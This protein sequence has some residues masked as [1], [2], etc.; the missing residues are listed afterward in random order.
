[1]RLVIVVAVED[2]I[3]DQLYLLFLLV[4][5]EVLWHLFLCYL[6]FPQGRG[7]RTLDLVHETLHQFLTETIQWTA[8][9]LFPALLLLVKSIEWV[10]DRFV[11]RLRWWMWRVLM[12]RGIHGIRLHFNILLYFL[13]L[14]LLGWLHFLRGLVIDVELVLEEFAISESGEFLT[15]LHILWVTVLFTFALESLVL[16]L[17]EFVGVVLEQRNS[18]RSIDIPLL[19]ADF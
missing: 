6:S 2:W 17:S 18:L 5:I 14:V 10:A 11:D 9:H 19:F 1:M 12:M 13:L 3:I 7:V 4:I 16:G 15:Q 8:P